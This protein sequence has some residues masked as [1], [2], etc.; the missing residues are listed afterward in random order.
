MP[1]AVALHRT[2]NFIQQTAGGVD[3]LDI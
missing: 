3:I 1:V 2:F